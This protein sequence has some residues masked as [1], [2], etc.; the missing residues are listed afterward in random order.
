MALTMFK[1]AVQEVVAMFW[2]CATR[3]VTLHVLGVPAHSFVASQGCEPR[4]A[5]LY[6][7][8]TFV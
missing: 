7:G 5:I 4:F 8:I 2:P 6:T 3:P 1:E